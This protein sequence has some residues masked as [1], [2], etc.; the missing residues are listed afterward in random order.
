[1]SAN[2][3]DINSLIANRLDQWFPTGMPRHHRVPFTITR[4]A[5]G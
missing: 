5:A 1:M 4:G 2:G 3:T